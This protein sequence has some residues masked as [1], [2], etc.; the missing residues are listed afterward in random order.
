MKKLFV[1]G[2][3]SKAAYVAI[4]AFGIL[5]VATLPSCKAWRTI[6]TT[7][8]YTAANDSAKSTITIQSKTVEEYQGHKK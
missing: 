8:S 1:C 6:T 3:M 2:N 7:S 4:I 5:S